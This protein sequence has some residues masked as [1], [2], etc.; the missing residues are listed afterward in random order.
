MATTAKLA[1]GVQFDPV[2]LAWCPAGVVPL[3]VL[4]HLVRT[5]AAATV[6]TWRSG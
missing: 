6:R 5:A 3:M 2:D 4:H 1:P